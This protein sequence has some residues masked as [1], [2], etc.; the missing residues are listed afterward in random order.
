MIKQ[1]R[2]DFYLISENMFKFVTDTKIIPG[3]RTDHSGITLKLKLIDSERGRGYW[4]F[5]NTLLKDKDYVSL[6][7]NTI[8]DVTKTYVSNENNL[9]HGNI[10]NEEIQ[11]HINDQLF[12]ETLL[13][14]IRG[15][16]IKYSSEKKKKRLK[17]EKNTRRRH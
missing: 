8:D 1:A 10:S 14:M 9:N 3:Y 17:E 13:M 5:N 4:K 12:L 2:L 11:F 6:I 15:N 7:K 16:T